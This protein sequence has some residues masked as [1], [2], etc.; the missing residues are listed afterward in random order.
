MAAWEAAAASP[1]S[2][3]PPQARAGSPPGPG[4][5]QG[6]GRA[7]PSACHRHRAARH[8]ARSPAGSGAPGGRRRHF[9]PSDPPAPPALPGFPSPRGFLGLKAVGDAELWSGIR[10][11]DGAGPDQGERREEGAVQGL[12]SQA[13][14]IP[15]DTGRFA[16]LLGH[17]AGTG[18]RAEPGVPAG[19]SELSPSPQAAPGQQAGCSA[20]LTEQS[21]AGQS[22][23][24]RWGAAGRA[25]NFSLSGRSEDGQAA[26]CQPGPADNGT[27]GCTLHGLE[28]GTRYHL[29]IQPLA[30]GDALNISLQTG[31]GTAGARE[32]TPGSSFSSPCFGRLQEEEESGSFTATVSGQCLL[33]TAA[34]R[35]SSL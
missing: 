2:S 35:L 32:G 27:Y 18:L 31:T 8:R 30:G 14:A 22:V 9:A 6:G 13:R 3:A 19:L 26:G 16:P 34:L 24:L 15:G 10:P 7:A 17:G 20:N 4:R 5:C 25:C 33:N 1:A 11:V 21:V 23:R 29:R 12:P 28:A